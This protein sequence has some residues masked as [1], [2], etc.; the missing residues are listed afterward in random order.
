MVDR[1]TL[2]LERRWVVRSRGYRRGEPLSPGSSF[3]R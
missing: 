3:G 1:T 2:T